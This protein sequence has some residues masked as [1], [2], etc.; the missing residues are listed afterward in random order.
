M[1]RRAVS[2]RSA[3]DGVTPETRFAVDLAQALG[4][5]LAVEDRLALAVSGGPDSMAMLALAQRAFPGRVIAATVDHGLRTGAAA[6]A[7][8]VASYCRAS[9]IPHAI[10]KPDAG[11]VPKT[12]QADARHKRYALLGAW[13]IDAGAI[14]LLTAHHLDDQAETFLMR[15]VR[16]S[17]VAGLGGIRARW[18]W[19]RHRWHHGYPKGGVAGVADIDAIAVVRP[20]LGWR[21]AELAE[22]VA[23]A[24]LPV[25]DDPSNVDDRFD[26]VRM[27][28]LLADQRVLDPPGIAQAAAACADAN[29]AIDAIMDMLHRE[30]M[31][32]SDVYARVYDVTALPREI[33]RRLVRD[34]IGYVRNIDSVTEGTWSSATNV[35]ALLDALEAG[36]GATIAGVMASAD[37]MIWYFRPAP[38]RRAT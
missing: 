25:V 7:A 38:P 20:L 22:V 15:A 31:R 19:E 30:R 36:S 8:M 18:M 3:S 6:E 17:G 10:L 29:A 35:E 37:G 2:R 14:M 24:G 32:D 27:R 23:T 33:R 12:I 34:A 28:S 16:G 4:R 13:A 9:G 26:R 11:W 5:A 1:W 21:R